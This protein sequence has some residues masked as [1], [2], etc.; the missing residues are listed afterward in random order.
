MDYKRFE[1]CFDDGDEERWPRWCVIEWVQVSPSGARAGNVVETFGR[2][3]QKEAEDLAMV[4]NY[5]HSFGV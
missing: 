3:Q 1:A 5:E 4:L 2:H